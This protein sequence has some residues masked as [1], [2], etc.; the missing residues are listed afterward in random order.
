MKNKKS[1][2]ILLPAAAGLW[3]Y[4]IYLVVSGMGNSNDFMPSNAQPMVFSDSLVKGQDTFR[5]SLAYNDPFLKKIKAY[6]PSER[7]SKPETLTP[8]PKAQPK[9]KQPS[10]SWPT[11]TYGG[12]IAGGG[13]KKE[14]IILIIGSQEE[15]GKEGDVLRGV[16][17]LQIDPNVIDLEYKGDIKKISR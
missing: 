8:K 6:S 3:A 9:P 11:I 17:I 14:V 1:L 12:S 2:Y 7:A 16:K 10:V 15:I 5:L 4:I 13:G